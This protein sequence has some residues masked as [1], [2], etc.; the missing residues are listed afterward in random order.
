ML[1][2]L[3][4][5]APANEPPQSS[6]WSNAPGVMAEMAQLPAST[7][8][9][10]SN[11]E[12]A[13]RLARKALV[14]KVVQCTR[15]AVV[16]GGA[17][18]AFQRQAYSSLHLGLTHDQSLRG[19][20]D[21]LLTVLASLCSNQE[22]TPCHEPTLAKLVSVCYECLVQLRDVSGALD[23]CASGFL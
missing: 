7:S 21:G 18:Q 12:L 2:A 13:E 4:V 9:Q 10:R 22:L 16:S 23:S 15:Q 17:L 8:L 5:R 6:Q 14:G 1:K 19:F 3:S 11:S 20:I